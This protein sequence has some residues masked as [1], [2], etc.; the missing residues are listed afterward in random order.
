MN[1]RANN[2]TLQRGLLYVLAFILLW[3]WLRPLDEITDTGNLGYFVMFAFLSVTLYYLN[4]NGILSFAIKSVYIVY[5]LYHLYADVTL[6]NPVAAMLTDLWDNIGLTI[7]R[8]WSLLSDMYRSLLFFILLWLMTYLIHYWISVRK[9]M[10]M[11]YIMTVVYISL[12]DTFTTFDAKGAIIRVII[13]GFLLLGMLAL[14]RLKNQESLAASKRATGRWMVPLVIMIGSSSVLAFAAPKIDP[15]WPDPVPHLKALAGQNETGGGGSKL[16][17][18][19]DDSRL[20]GP[21]IGDPKTVFTAD[22][23]REHYWRIESK[24]TYTGKGWKRSDPE[25]SLPFNPG[26]EVPLKIT[27]PD[28]E[29]DPDTETLKVKEQYS[30]IVYPYG[31]N[32]VQGNEEGYFSMSTDTAKITSLQGEEEVKLEE[33]T[34]E[35]TNP[36][37]SLKGLESASADSFAESSQ[38]FL[39]RY[40]QLP[41]T[42]PDRVR[43]LAETI[44][45]DQ[46]N[47]YQKTKAIEEY[48]EKENFVYEQFEVPI[49]EEGQDYVDQFL[50]ETQMGY[51]DNYSTAMVVLVR[52]LGIPARWAKGYTEGEYQRTID[53]QYKTYKVTNNNAHSWVEVFFPGEGWVPFEPTVGFT[54]S[55]IVNY[56]YELPETEETAVPPIEQETPE[57]DLTPEEES[58]SG[59]SFNFSIKAL[60]DDAVTFVEDNWGKIIMAVIA[61]AIIAYAAFLARRRWLP[62]VLIPYYKFKKD[63][64]TFPQ[65]YVALLRQ[66]GRYGL[67]M[68]DGQTLR[69]YSRYVDSFFGTREMTSLTER[70]ERG[71]YGQKLTEHD[72]KQLQELWENLIKRTTG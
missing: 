61:L 59:N 30:H 62:Y 6:L 47:W 25:E 14:L 13:L 21:F 27:E 58:A 22:V 36:V 16:G 69:S 31:I 49:P 11:F 2:R 70:Y 44:T 35:Y 1:D 34:V 38:L 72:W 51:C 28:P 17:Y 26:E 48:F 45:A 40:T 32:S 60:W 42:L 65:A 43:E 66:L 24:D 53:T 63:K 39:E 19:Q 5:S 57:K 8:E 46:E 10:L 20:G 55:S 64:D 3:E 18:G 68:D 4:L 41:D 23:V 54:G 29:R 33:Y 71:L 7:G 56:D 15:V 50:F 52:S 12:L 67:K 9:T 37:Y